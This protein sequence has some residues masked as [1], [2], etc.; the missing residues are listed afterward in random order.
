MDVAQ[1]SV[2]F[3]REAHR[4]K[5]GHVA[6]RLAPGGLACQH[7]PQ[8][9]DG[10]VGRQLLY[11]ALDAGL[12]LVFHKDLC[13]AQ[14]IG[15]QLGLARAVAAHRVQ[16]HAGLDHVGRHDGGVGLV[17]GDGRDDVGTAR[18][19]GCRRCGHHAQA[20]HGCQVALQFRCGGRVNVKHPQLVH[21][22]KGVERYGL[23]LTLR[24]VANERHAAR[25]GPCQGPCGHGRCGRS[26][27]RGGQRQ[28]GHQQ[29]VAG[30]HFGQH[31]KRHHRGQPADGVAGV[32]VDVLEAV[33]RVVGHGHELDHAA[34]AVAGHAGRLVKVLPAQVVA[35]Q[36]LGQLGHEAGRGDVVNELGQRGKVDQAGHESLRC[37]AAHKTALRTVSIGLR[38]PAAP[39]RSRRS[40]WGRSVNQKSNVAVQRKKFSRGHAP[41][42]SPQA[43]QIVL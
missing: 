7:A 36:V 18:R 14:H 21:P 39:R 32:P 42:N 2:V 22:Q 20:G 12:R 29:R 27:Q 37:K 25:I 11:V 5:H 8:L 35:V 10:V 23:E 1:C 43:A 41:A 34:R 38:W 19:L 9:G 26:A 40:F 17:G 16:V 4:V 6:G 3:E 33:V 31:T 30:S 28:L 13:G 24:A 15:V